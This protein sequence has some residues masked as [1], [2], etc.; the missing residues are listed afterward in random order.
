MLEFVI[1]ENGSVTSCDFGEETTLDDQT[2]LD[3]VRAAVL[4]WKIP[5]PTKVDLV[6]VRYPFRLT[7]TD[8]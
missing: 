7:A 6:K 2:L 4:R 5:Q 3:C 1:G 8:S